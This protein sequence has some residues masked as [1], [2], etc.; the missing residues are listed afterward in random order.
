VRREDMRAGQKIRIENL[1]FQTD[2][3]SI[4]PQSYPILDNIY[5]FLE[6]NPDVVVE[7]GGHTNGLAET[8]YADRLSTERAR[9]VADY[10]IGKGISR[11]RI[12]YRGYGKRYPIDTNDTPE[13][14]R[15]N[16][17]VEIKIIGLDG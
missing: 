10:L 6:A 15:R 5:R 9:A 4:K 16:Q 12:Q 17:R 14:R 11:E 1:Q 8:E 7:I 2:I 13:G 3:A